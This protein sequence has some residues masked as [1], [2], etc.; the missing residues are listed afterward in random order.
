MDYSLFLLV[1]IV[2]NMSKSKTTETIGVKPVDCLFVG[3]LSILCTSSDLDR[4][5][6]PFGLIRAE[7][8]CDSN[9]VPFGFVTFETI[10][11]ARAAMETRQGTLVHG[12]MLRYHSFAICLQL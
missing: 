5:F 4:L 10:D 1:F 11:H 3:N 6:S 9:F 7:I 8:R 12:R 2:G